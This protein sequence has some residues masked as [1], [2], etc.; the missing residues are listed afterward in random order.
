M[1]YILNTI[2]EHP[3]GDHVYKTISYFEYASNSTRFI[4][5]GSDNKFK[6]WK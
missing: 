3:H 4:T 5:I 6:I 2:V 1:D